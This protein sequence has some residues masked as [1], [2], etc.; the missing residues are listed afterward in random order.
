MLAECGHDGSDMQMIDSE[1]IDEC[2][3]RHTFRCRICG[4]TEKIVERHERI[5]DMPL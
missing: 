5:T 4:A 3:T 2:H 1:P